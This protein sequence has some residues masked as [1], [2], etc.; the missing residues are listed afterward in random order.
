MRCEYQ[1]R[2]FA[3]LKHLTHHEKKN[4]SKKTKESYIRQEWT[5][6]LSQR[7]NNWY[8]QFP[9]VYGMLLKEGGIL[10]SGKHGPVETFFRRAAAIKLKLR[11]Y[12]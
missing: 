2:L 12:F 10:Q 9:D 8:T 3:H 5:T 6:F 7:S 11:S 1:S 4:T